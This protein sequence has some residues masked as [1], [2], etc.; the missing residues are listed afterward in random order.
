MNKWV[1]LSEMIPELKGSVIHA[2]NMDVNLLKNGLLKEGF[3]VYMVD[4]DRIVDELT[5]FTEIARVLEFPTYFGKNWGAWNDSLNNDFFELAPLKTA[6]VWEHADHSFESDAQTFLQAVC[7]L[8]NIALGA[9]LAR[10][11][12]KNASEVKQIE[13]FFIGELKGFP[14][15]M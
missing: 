15:V 2:L 3:R 12:N 10:F 9:S 7:D 1:N 11:Y 5:F 4:G 13:V 14:R 6:I 8:Y